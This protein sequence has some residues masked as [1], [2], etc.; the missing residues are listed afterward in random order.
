MAAIASD[1]EQKAEKEAKKLNLGSHTNLTNPDRPFLS[2]M[3]L[4]AKS[5]NVR[6]SFSLLDENGVYV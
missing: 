2:T 6:S 3:E 5:H 4:N 1:Y